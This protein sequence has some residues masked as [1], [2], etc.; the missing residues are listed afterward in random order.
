M[1]RPAWVIVEI[2][3]R[4]HQR[5]AATWAINSSSDLGRRGGIAGLPAVFVGVGLASSAVCAGLSG[6]AAATATDDS[7]A[8]ATACIPWVVAATGASGGDIPLSG[9]GSA[10]GDGSAGSA[11]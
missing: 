8:A 4:D 5:L 7:T 1:A 10:A 6:A 3:G 2:L 11:G 9:A